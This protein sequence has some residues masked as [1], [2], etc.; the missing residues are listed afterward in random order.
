[1]SACVDTDGFTASFLSKTGPA[2]R[3]VQQYGHHLLTTQLYQPQAL[4]Q[5]LEGTS[6]N[7]RVHLEQRRAER[8][9]GPC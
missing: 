2:A 5:S 3:R 6:V 4:T 7:A 9:E 1:M 8:E